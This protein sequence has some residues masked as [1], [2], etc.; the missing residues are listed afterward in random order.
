MNYI[1]ILSKIFKFLIWWYICTKR[2]F[3]FAS[4]LRDQKRV[5][6]SETP[7]RWALYG[8]FLCFWSLGTLFVSPFLVN[9]RFL[10]SL[11]TPSEWSSLNQS[12][13]LNGLV[14]RSLASLHG[15]LVFFGWWGFPFACLCL[16]ESWIH[17]W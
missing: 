2:G 1:I 10:V 6:L 9:L 15:N 11:L 16:N 8:R 13:T 17:S 5:Q 7:V 3:L 14:L 12:R 4:L